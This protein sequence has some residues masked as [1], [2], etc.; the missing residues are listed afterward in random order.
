MQPISA[1]TRY[2]TEVGRD[3][4]SIFKQSMFLEMGFTKDFVDKYT[5]EMESGEGYKETIFDHNGKRIN[6][7][8]GVY[9][10]DFLYGVANDMGADT[11]VARNKMG[12]GFQAG[13]LIIAINK[14]LEELKAGAPQTV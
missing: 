14:K 13:E 9:S 1:V 10:L 4:H 12:R 11:T 6:K 5:Y 3:G 7:C 8:V 2:I